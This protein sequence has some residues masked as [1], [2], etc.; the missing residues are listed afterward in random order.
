MATKIDFP[1][2]TADGQ[3]FIESTTNVVYTYVGNPPDG[4]WSAYAGEDSE[5]LSGFFVKVA[6]DNMTGNLT[7]GTDK[8]TLNA[9]DGSASFAAVVNCGGL[10]KDSET[11]GGV[12]LGSTG[13][14]NI[15]RVN[16]ADNSVF[17]VFSGVNQNV[18]IKAEGSASFAGSITGADWDSLGGT[19]TGYFLGATGGLYVRRAS[20][21]NNSDVLFAGYKGSNN[22]ALIQAD[23]NASFAGNVTCSQNNNFNDIDGSGCNLGRNGGIT[24]QRISTEGTSNVFQGLLA[25]NITSSIQANGTATF[26]GTVLVGDGYNSTSNATA[27]V[28]LS[29]TGG[30]YTQA[31]LAEADKNIWVARKGTNVTSYISITGA[32]VFTSV[33]GAAFSINLE[34]DDDTKYTATTNEEGETELV[35]NG[36]VLDVK[37]RLQKA[38]AALLSL[39]TAAAA[40]TDF[41]SLKSAIATAL[42]NI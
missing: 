42:A 16:G 30:V 11:S 14:V 13:I 1:L 23:G 10:D 21:A 29:K 6:G 3:V 22:V 19:G 8:I 35:Y 18:L 36:A 27:G 24:A 34:A 12:Q 28:Y 20:T 5:N 38:D 32:A 39:K 26:E 40:A 41:A 33:N 7:L 31:T 4:Y 15:Q 17:Q 25:N 9:T 2:A 37:D